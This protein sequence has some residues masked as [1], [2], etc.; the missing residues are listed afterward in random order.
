MKILRI[1]VAKLKEY[2]SFRVLY[3]KAYPLLVK[4][5]IL[6][7][8]RLINNGSFNDAWGIAGREEIHGKS[9][10]EK[11]A[12]DFTRLVKVDKK[13]R[14]GFLLDPTE[15]DNENI[16]QACH[17]LG[18]DYMLYEIRDPL[19]F[20]KLR[21]SNCNALVICPSHDNNLIRSVFH[22]AAQ[23]ISSEMNIMLYPTAREL[24]FYEAKRTLNNFLM[25]HNIPHP[26][27]YVF[28]DLKAAFTFLD[29]SKY[30]IVFKTH[31]G[32]SS[33]GVEILR[34]KKQAL[35]LARHLFHDYYLRK[36]ETESRSIEWGYMLVQEYLEDV[37]EFRIIKIGD[38]WFGYEKWKTDK[39]DF[40]S[41]SGVLKWI[42]PTGELLDF[43]FQIASQ[44]QFT[45]MCFDIFQNKQGEYLVNELQTWFGSYDPT[46][47]YVDNIPGRYYRNGKEWIFEPGMFNVHG[48]MAL[49]M[50][51]LINE[52]QKAK[53]IQ[54]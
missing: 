46:E 37:R 5:K 43:C 36:M 18:I 26:V 54:H 24:S 11:Y 42:N 17:I 8:L 51:D 29:T 12:V 27:T 53:E 32:S 48:S 25:I 2:R 41:G 34:N 20:D 49:R 14:I 6:K 38:S 7:T 19:L 39:Q 35:K 47:M 28:Y 50:V 30:P 9:I 1:I 4:F 21:E 15:R 3:A 52:L 33:S 40:M 44:H 13:Y 23:V 10:I 31:L 16:D 22:E 45:T